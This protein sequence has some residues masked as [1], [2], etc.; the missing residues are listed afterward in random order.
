MISTLQAQSLENLNGINVKLIQT[1][2]QFSTVELANGVMTV[3]DPIKSFLKICDKYEAPVEKL[4]SLNQ[5][6]EW[7]SEKTHGK[8]TEILDDLSPGTVML[9]LN[10]VYFKADW[11]SPFNPEKT[12]KGEFGSSKNKLK[13]VE[14]MT[15]QSKFNY[16]F[17]RTCQV[18]ELPFKNDSMSAFIILPY[19]GADLD[20]FVESILTD[21]YAN[22]IMEN[23]EPKE[24][25]LNLPKF[26]VEFKSKLKDVLKRLGM[27]KA[28]GDADFSGINGFGGLYVDNVIHKT[29]L[30]VDEFGSEGAAVTVVDMRKGEPTPD[31]K[32]IVNRPFVIILKS[33]LLPKNNDFLFVGKIESI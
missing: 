13:E 29:Y 28:F 31:V 6:N 32:L 33:K 2:K 10:A 18:I 1:F 22:H 21:D 25:R 23:M 12:T 30:K 3:F 16:F 7:C 8:I 15:Q 4:I 19:E 14:M 26:K 11:V 5:V 24:I 27:I 17:D 9:L 20:H